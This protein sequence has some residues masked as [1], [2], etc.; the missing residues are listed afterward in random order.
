MKT[1]LIQLGLLVNS[2]QTVIEGTGEN[3]NA[4]PPNA[5][6]RIIDLGRGGADATETQ[7]GEEL[8]LRITVDSPYS[9]YKNIY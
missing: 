4:T 5:R 7:L 8:E 1:V 3:V 6:L 9:K 2:V